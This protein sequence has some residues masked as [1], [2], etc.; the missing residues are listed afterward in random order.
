MGP[1][2]TNNL[3]AHLE[4]RSVSEL[5]YALKS[6][7]EGRFGDVRVHGEVLSARQVSSGHLYFTLKDA[8]AQ[9]PCVMW[10]STVARMPGRIQDGMQVVAFGDV[11]IYP[12]HGKYQLV[13]TRVVDAGIGAL[14]A[15][16]EALRQRLFAEGLLDPQRRR[17]LPFLPRRVGLVTAETGAAV[18][19]LAS[20][21]LRR[22]PA[23]IVLSPCRVQGA[24]AGADVARALAL[25]ARTP[26]VEVIVVGRGGGSLEDLW[27][28]NEEA[29]VRAIASCPTP[30][31]SAVGHAI[32]KPLSDDAADAAAITPT[33]AGELVVPSLAALRD[34]LAQ[35]QA[36]LVG[37]LQR[38]LQDAGHRVANLRARLSD[39]RRVTAEQQQ[40]VDD[41]RIR[42][43]RAVHRRV[44]RARADLERARAR[45]RNLHPRATLSAARE[46]VA[47][48]DA[49]LERATRHLLARRGA[50]LAHA[51]RALTLL[52]PTA[53]LERG[54]AIVRGA[55][56]R[57]LRDAREVGPGAAIEVVLRRGALEAN[58]TASHERHAWQPEEP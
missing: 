18:R 4:A 47:S 36:R 1:D 3:V 14:L 41:A 37:Q 21:I 12:P 6:H 5:T 9:L 45:L 42:L 35:L 25:V 10:R 56:G 17:A 11:Q 53:S 32:D 28:F 38:R 43:E 55:E 54:Y 50:E 46:R 7:I 15:Q 8:S 24:G 48:L 51:R 31:V 34:E 13:V 20:S 19:D 26:G 40:R 44:E 58:V 16:L 57:V 27:A 39:P 33:A 2:R 30:V 52:G 23:E 49:R 22:F 29:L